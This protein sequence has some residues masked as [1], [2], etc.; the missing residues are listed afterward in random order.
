MR[1]RRCTDIPVQ[2]V[3]TM[4]AG[5]RGGLRALLQSEGANGSGTHRQEAKTHNSDNRHVGNDLR[6]ISFLDGECTLT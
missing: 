4:P 3:P 5:G 1:L 6:G 2:V